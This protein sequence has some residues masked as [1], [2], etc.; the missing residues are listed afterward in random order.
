MK[1]FSKLQKFVNQKFNFKIESSMSLCAMKK[2]SF[3]EVGS[4]KLG[5][6]WP[7]VVGL[8]LVE[9]LLPTPQ[10][11]SLNPVIGYQQC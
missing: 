7:V 8:Q 4:G 1:L 10:I 2:N 9:Q 5:Y 3:V 11:R 6:C